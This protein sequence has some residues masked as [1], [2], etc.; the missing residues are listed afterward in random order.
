MSS[1]VQ[2]VRKE[3]NG[4]VVGVAAVAALGGLLFGYDTGV[5]SGALLFIEKDLNASTF[6]QSAIV[7]SL[8]L[9]AVGGAIAAGYLASAFGRRPPTIAAGIVFAI[10]AIGSALA[11]DVWTLV[12]ARF[13]LGIAVGAA[14]FVA[15]MYIGEL[16]P[17]KIRGGLVSFNQLMIT[18]G[19]LVAY[20]V[21]FGLKGID[22]N[23]R[24]M[25]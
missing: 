9:G 11:P 2:D 4:F 19:I 25:L 22:N 23:W 21:D 1:F 13:V 7:G 15:P 16:V 18:V 3:T 20:I 6:D 5:I 14:S 17:P 24:W 12:V 8:L 10:G